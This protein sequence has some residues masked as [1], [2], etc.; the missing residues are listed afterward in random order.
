[1]NKYIAK[2]NH[3]AND[4]YVIPSKLQNIELNAKNISEAVK[5]TADLLKFEMLNEGDYDIIEMNEDYCEINFGDADTGQDV[6]YV[7]CEK[8]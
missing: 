3:L 4:E 1:M 6:S 5:I 7:I 2:L 8:E